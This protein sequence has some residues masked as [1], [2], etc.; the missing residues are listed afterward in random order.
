M[1][2][3]EMLVDPEKVEWERIALPGIQVKY[4]YKNEQTGA[5]MVNIFKFWG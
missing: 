5:S 4:L 3:K 2:R 1:E